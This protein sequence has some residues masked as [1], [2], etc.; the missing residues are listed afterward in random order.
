MIERYWLIR[1]WAGVY[2][3]NTTQATGANIERRW[4]V[5]TDLCEGGLSTAHIARW[6]SVEVYE[7]VSTDRI[8]KISDTGFAKT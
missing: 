5:E 1:S 7:V 8:A 6:W 4:G 2:E 3:R